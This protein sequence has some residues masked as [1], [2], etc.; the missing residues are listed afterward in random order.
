MPR[1]FFSG[2]ML[3]LGGWLF[4]GAV[5]AVYLIMERGSGLAPALFE[6]PTSAIRLFASAMMLVGGLFGLLKWPYGGSLALIGAAVFTALGALMAASGAH[7]ALWGDE[8]LFGVGALV[9]SIL[10]LSFRRA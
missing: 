3:L 7:R 6:P 5:R 10:V 4:Y 2:L 9:Q 8:I 1:R